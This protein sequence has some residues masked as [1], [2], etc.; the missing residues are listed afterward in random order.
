MDMRKFIQRDIANSK[1]RSTTSLQKKQE[2][3]NALDA[4]VGKDTPIECLRI[5]SS[6]WLDGFERFMYSTP[7]SKKGTKT[8]SPSTAAFRKKTLVSYCR[9][10]I[11]QSLCPNIKILPEDGT[12][13]G[14]EIESLPVPD[15]RKDME[16]LLSMFYLK[17]ERSNAD[18]I[19]EE[20]LTSLKIQIRGLDYAILSILLC[21]IGYNGLTDV[22]KVEQT[23]NVVHLPHLDVDIAL[24][25]HILAL[26]DWLCLNGSR[27]DATVME[28][29]ALTAM[30]ST[31]LSFKDGFKEPFTQWIEMAI[32]AGI[33]FKDARRIIDRLY[34]KQD[35]E[36]VPGDSE[37]IQGVIQGAFDAVVSS[38][39]NFSY[40]WYCIKSAVSTCATD[41]SAGQ[42][43]L[44]LIENEANIHPIDSFCPQ[45]KVISDRDG[46]KEVRKDRLWDSL[47]LVKVNQLQIEAINRFLMSKRC[48]FIYGILGKGGMTYS[49]IRDVEVAIIRDFFKDKDNR[50]IKGSADLTGRKVQVLTG[51][52]EGYDGTIAKVIFDKDRNVH[53]LILKLQGTAATA[54]YSADPDY[55]QL[56]E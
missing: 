3:L 36:S 26:F 21:G 20:A 16:R 5:I 35:D 11:K 47:L 54:T 50:R 8:L 52:Y 17:M 22:S 34:S 32:S 2:C 44:R 33:S 23:D 31:T 9:E 42:A 27:K 13:Y 39:K 56:A 55:L 45:M 24:P 4:Y 14:K 19:P 28:H 18:D 41:N 49:K 30:D 48:G 43:L 40:S 10:A 25:D 7:I 29:E 6:D 12:E 37:S 51:L 53:R 15:R 46:R 38:L 1:G